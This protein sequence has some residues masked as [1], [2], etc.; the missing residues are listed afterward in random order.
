MQIKKLPNK[1]IMGSFFNSFH[2]MP[3][4]YRTWP[5][6]LLKKRIVLYGLPFGAQS[7]TNLR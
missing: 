3:S 2:S 6:N 1:K 5:G 4:G 7:S